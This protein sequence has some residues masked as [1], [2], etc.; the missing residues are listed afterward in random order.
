MDELSGNHHHDIDSENKS[1]WEI[2][3]FTGVPVPAA[4]GL[5]LL[6]MIIS[7]SS[8]NEL[9]KVSPFI[10]LLVVT[11]VSFLMI[12]RIPTYAIKQIKISKT[13]FIFL[14]LGF[15]LFFSFLF[16]NTFE[17]LTILGFIYIL[18]IP[19]SFIHFSKLRKKYAK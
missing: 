12:S 15:V 6:P 1:N 19:I 9:L 14:A 4:A 7:F 3:F 16:Q 5:V 8:F 10:I 17:T 18:S 2:N 11:F 13:I